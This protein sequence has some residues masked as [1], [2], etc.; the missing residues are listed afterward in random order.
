MRNLRPNPS[1]HA[2]VMRRGLDKVERARLVKAPEERLYG[3]QIATK[4]ISEGV[5]ASKLAGEHGARWIDLNC[6]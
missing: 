4:V 5:A 3:F 1:P 2:A 6:G